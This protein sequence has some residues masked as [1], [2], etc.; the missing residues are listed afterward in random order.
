MALISQCMTK[1]DNASDKEHHTQC[2]TLH[3][4][5]ELFSASRTNLLN[6]CHQVTHSSCSHQSWAWLLA[7]AA[8]PGL[9]F[10]RA[11]PPFWGDFLA[12]CNESQWVQNI[13]M[14]SDSSVRNSASYREGLQIS[15]QQGLSDFFFFLFFFFSVYHFSKSPPAVTPRLP[16]GYF[17]KRK[18]F[19]I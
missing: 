6:V 17:W 13:Q 16:G 8:F 7:Q 2:P 3:V 9:G 10:S 12:R 19:F 15:L 14:Y 4:S 1:S 18:I 11:S 5:L